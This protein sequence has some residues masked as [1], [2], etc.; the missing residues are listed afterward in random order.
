MTGWASHFMAAGAGAFIGTL[1]P[2]RSSQAS[3][4]AEEFYGAL[5]TGADLGQASL[6]A[7]RATKNHADPTWLAYTIYGDPA[8]LCASQH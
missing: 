7:R 6:T 3:L 4:F 5:V 8:A 1:W 2:V